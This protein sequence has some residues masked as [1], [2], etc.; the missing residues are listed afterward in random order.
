MTRS[1]GWG[2]LRANPGFGV[3]W[4]IPL[5]LTVAYLQQAS[6]I[7]KILSGPPGVGVALSQQDS[8]LWAD[9]S[10]MLGSE[11]STG[12]FLVETTPILFTHTRM[13][14]F[15][16]QDHTAL[17]GNTQHPNRDG[18]PLRG[19]NGRSVPST[20]ELRSHFSQDFLIYYELNND[21][22]KLLFFILWPSLISTS[23]SKHLD[24]P[25]RIVTYIHL[26]ADVRSFDYDNHC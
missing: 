13:L 18:S 21:L 17:A 20:Q 22:L 24:N 10:E 23:V 9:H 14:I 8:Q 11:N 5:L 4:F 12:H 15:Y 2:Y 7:G 16:I 1:S 25:K 6:F 3:F 26:F 19:S